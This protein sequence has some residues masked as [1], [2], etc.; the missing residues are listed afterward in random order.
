MKLFADDVKLYSSLDDYD[1]EFVCAKQLANTWQIWIAFNKCT[2]QHRISSQGSRSTSNP[3][4]IWKLVA[5]QSNEMHDLGII[6]I[7]SWILTAIYLHSSV[8]LLIGHSR[9]LHLLFG[10][11]CRT[12]LDQLTLLVLLNI[13][14]KTI[15]LRQPTSPRTVQRYHNTS[16]S[17]ATMAL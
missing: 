7:I 14:L 17:H 9:L 4:Y 15:C 16:N 5:D 10:I 8:L 6:I 2:G 12:Q 3:L 11:L 1:L 13:D